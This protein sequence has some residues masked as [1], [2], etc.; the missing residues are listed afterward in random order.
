MTRIRI[1]VNKRAR[2]KV[3]S[4]SAPFSAQHLGE[5]CMSAVVRVEDEQYK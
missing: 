3:L 5:Y 2:L 1:V 4:L